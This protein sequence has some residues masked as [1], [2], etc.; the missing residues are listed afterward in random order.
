MKTTGIIASL[1]I[2]CVM[3]A[4]ACSK[5]DKGNTPTA[6]TEADKIKD[7]TIAYT[8]DIYLWYNQIRPVSRPGT[9]PIRPPLWKRSALIV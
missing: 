5:K 6:T 1:A 4:T 8:R 2:V 9:I 3:L 7:T